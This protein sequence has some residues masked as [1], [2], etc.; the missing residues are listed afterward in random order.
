MPGDCRECGACCFSTSDTYVAVTARDKDR[1]GE[2]AEQVTQKIGEA[3]FLKMKEGRC[4]ELQHRGGDWI[5]GIYKIRPDACRQLERGSPD[6]LA[7]R[8]LKRRTA[9]ATSKRLLSIVG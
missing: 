3:S 4:A 1:L 5:C 6:C 2:K 7:E 8:A 9:L